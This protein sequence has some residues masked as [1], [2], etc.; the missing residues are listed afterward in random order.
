[1]RAPK[2]FRLHIGIFGRRN[3]GKSSILNALTQQNVSIVSE[4][5]GTTTDPVE[6]PMELLPLGPVLFIDTAGIDD[7]GNLGG[8]RVAK[9]LA[10][11]D[12]TDLGVIVTNF[13][14]WGEYELQLMETFKEREI[15]FI[16]VFNKAD[17]FPENIEIT[18]QLDSI[19]VKHVSTSAT[20]EMGISDLRQLLL[21][22]APSD[23]INRPSIL[24]DLVGPGEA[25]ILVVPIDKEAPKGRLILPQV[26]SIRDLL[27][28]DSF[29]VVVKERELREA[30]SRFNKPPKLIVTDSQAFLKV[31]ADTPP[32]IPLTSFSI[33][34]ARFQGDL[35]EMVRGAMAI[36]TLKTGDK[37]LIA[38]ACSHHPIGEDIGTVKIPRWLTQYVG[39]KLE[40]DNIRG[41]DFPENISEYKLIIHCGACMWNRRTMLSRIMKARQ[42]KVPL[43]NYGLTIAYSLGIFERALQ[44]FPAALEVFKSE[45]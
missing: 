3:V 16:I 18:S 14:D 28:N 39:G 34:F 40:I 38:E 1:M 6:K 35:S 2:T 23:F 9:T 11:F 4:I 36:D 41:H 31:T 27:D 5:A 45:N 22:T 15:P 32:E 33:L 7:I 13:S 30:L 25:A 8:K 44:P 24:A 37:V 42:A 20:V 10:V 43:T 26:Q 21:N 17:V 29:C 19:K 12:R